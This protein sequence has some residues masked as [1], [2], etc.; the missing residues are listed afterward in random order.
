M[1]ESRK[2]Y[3]IELAVPSMTKDQCTCRVENGVLIVTTF[4]GNK[5]VCFTRTFPMPGDV[6]THKITAKCT[7]GILFLTLTKKTGKAANE[8]PVS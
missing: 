3:N 6:D 2:S 1:F 4:N 8:I 7:D 5:E